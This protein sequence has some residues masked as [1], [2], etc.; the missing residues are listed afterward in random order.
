AVRERLNRSKM[1][2][3]LLFVTALPLV[4]CHS[5][6]KPNRSAVEG[7]DFDAGLFY[8]TPCC[9]PFPSLRYWLPT[10][11]TTVPREGYCLSMSFSNTSE[12]SITVV[13]H[14]TLNKNLY[15]E[16]VRLFTM[17]DFKRLKILYPA[18]KALDVVRCFMPADTEPARV[19]E[20]IKETLANYRKAIFLGWG[21]GFRWDPYPHNC[22]N[23][24]ALQKELEEK[25]KSPS[26][27]V[28]ILMRNLFALKIVE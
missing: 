19:V 5:R 26:S 24:E 16:Q 27:G 10:T 1:W 2:L 12:C 25:L 21:K 20:T 22:T 13:H 6:L 23:Y 28:V 4:D 18:G 3:Y 17:D 9:C 14:G 11:T 8:K 7:E 15:C